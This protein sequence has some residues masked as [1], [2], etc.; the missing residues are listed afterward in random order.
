[1]ETRHTRQ[2]VASASG[3]ELSVAVVAI[4]SLLLPLAIAAVTQLGILISQLADLNT[5]ARTM[6]LDR[7]QDLPS[8]VHEEEDVE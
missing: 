8:A 7:Q 2:L 1:M 5:Y 6:R 4:L 3:D